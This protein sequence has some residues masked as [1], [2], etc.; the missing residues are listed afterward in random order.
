MDGV[1]D[2]RHHEHED[3]WEVRVRQ[4]WMRY[5]EEENGYTCLQRYSI[6]HQGQCERSWTGS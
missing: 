2:L 6:S 3:Y 1:Y 4:A 5:S